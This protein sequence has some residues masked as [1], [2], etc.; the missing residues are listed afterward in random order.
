MT[1]LR[2]CLLLHRLLSAQI[3]EYEHS[4]TSGASNF[5]CCEPFCTRTR[6]QTV[7]KHQIKQWTQFLIYRMPRTFIYEKYKNLAKNPLFDDDCWW[8]VTTTAFADSSTLRPTDRCSVTSTMFGAILT[9]WPSYWCSVDPDERATLS[10][11]NASKTLCCFDISFTSRQSFVS[12][13]HLV[14]L[15]VLHRFTSVLWLRP[16][17]ITSPLA[18]CESNAFSLYQHFPTSN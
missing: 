7:N 12:S 8:S 1:S 4:G 5:F 2:S 14:T 15:S 9:L 16:R 3:E 6:L 10:T 18:R 17:A 13:Q 11:L